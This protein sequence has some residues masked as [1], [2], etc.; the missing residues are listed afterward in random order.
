MIKTAY[1]YLYD[2]L[3]IGVFSGASSVLLVI[4][5]EFLTNEH[6][7]KAA[8]GLGAYAGTFVAVISAPIACIKFFN[9]VKTLK[10]KFF[11]NKRPKKINHV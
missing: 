10:I 5:P 2:N 7:L 4:V 8:A 6:L 3:R 11:K 1:C 9:E